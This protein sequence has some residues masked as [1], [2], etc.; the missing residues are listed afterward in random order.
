MPSDDVV[1]AIYRALLLREA[2]ASVSLDRDEAGSTWWAC[3]ECGKPINGH[4][5][6]ECEDES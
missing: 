4:T 5:E 2:H 1:R 3:P 6:H